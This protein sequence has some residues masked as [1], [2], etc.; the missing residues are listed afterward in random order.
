M[1][2]FDDIR[3]APFCKFPALKNFVNPTAGF[4]RTTNKSEHF[5]ERRI[6]TFAMSS[7]II[8][9]NRYEKCSGVSQNNTCHT[10]FN[11]KP[12]RAIIA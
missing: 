7:L 10:L 5:L 4:I 2:F 8:L 3:S 11:Y 9:G 1:T 12:R 6:S